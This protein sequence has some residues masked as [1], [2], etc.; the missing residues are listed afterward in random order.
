MAGYVYLLTNP[1]LPGLVKIGRTDRDPFARAAE[2][3]TTGVPTPFEVL[4]ALRVLDSAGV[5]PRVHQ[6]L[7]AQRVSG[8]REFFRLSLEAALHALYEE[9]WGDVGGTADADP[10]CCAPYARRAAAGLSGRG[11]AAL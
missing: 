8:G 6:R 9:G 4:A 7:E 1:S 5:D 2:L 3:Q 10:A 11:T